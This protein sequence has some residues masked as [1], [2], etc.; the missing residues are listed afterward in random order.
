MIEKLVYFF[1]EKYNYNIGRFKTLRYLFKGIPYGRNTTVSNCVIGKY[2][3]FGYD[4]LISNSSI[5]D[6]SYTAS[7]TKIHFTHIGRFCSIGWNVSIGGHEHPINRISSHG[8]SYQPIYNIAEKNTGKISTRR[9]TYIGNDVWIGC[10]AYIKAGVRV[11]DGAVVGASAV[12]TK[13]VPSYAV[14]AGN[15][16]QVIKYRFSDDIIK[17]LDTIKW[18]DWPTKEIRKRILIFQKDIYRP[19]DLFER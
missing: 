13:D 10:N 14:V 3:R 11:G 8:F 7:N 15:P 17:E 4:N 18:W 9:T 19:S 6:Y 1:K 5:G 2:C 12:V 16:A